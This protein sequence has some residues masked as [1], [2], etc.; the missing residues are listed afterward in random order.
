MPELKSNEEMQFFILQATI[1][2]WEPVRGGPAAFGRIDRAGWED[3]IDY[4][5]ELGL[6]PNPVTVD[7]LVIPPTMDVPSP[8]P[9]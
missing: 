7:Q 6:V 1:F 8:A 3:S 2:T 4:L 9:S 5:T